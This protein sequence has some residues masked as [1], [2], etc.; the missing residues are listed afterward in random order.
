[1]GQV[2]QRVWNFGR[3]PS[4]PAFP[5][6]L[7]CF[8]GYKQDEPFT[9]RWLRDASE[10]TPN[11]GRPMMFEKPA[12]TGLGTSGGIQAAAQLRLNLPGST[13]ASESPLQ[14]SGFGHT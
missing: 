6:R 13:L 9:R 12:S 4:P 3:P 7:P 8:V 2:S 1:M 10:E 11:N 14:T 5:D